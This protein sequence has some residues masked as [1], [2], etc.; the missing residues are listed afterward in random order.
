MTSIYY[1]WI[2]ACSWHISLLV[3]A[4]LFILFKRRTPKKK[5]PEFVPKPVYIWQE[6]NNKFPAE[7]S[8][9]VVKPPLTDIIDVSSSDVFGKRFLEGET[10]KVYEETIEKYGVGSCGPREFYGT[11]DIHKNF[12]SL[13]AETLGFEEGVLYSSWMAM[14]YSILKAIGDNEDTIIAYDV[15]VRMPYHEILGVCKTKHKYQF[16]LKTACQ[17]NPNVYEEIFEQVY[18]DWEKQFRDER[19][20]K[21]KWKKNEKKFI[22]IEGIFYNTGMVLRNVH[23]LIEAAQKWGFYVILDD[24]WALGIR[25]KNCLGSLDNNSVGRLSRSNIILLSALES[26]AFGSQGGICLCSHSIADFQ[27]LSASG[28]TFSASN[29]PY[30][31]AV[32]SETW[33][34][35]TQSYDYVNSDCP[36]KCASKRY[37]KLITDGFISCL[38]EKGLIYHL[39]FP[40]MPLKND[41][42]TSEHIFVL[43]CHNDRTKA[44]EVLKRWQNEC[45]FKATLTDDEKAVRIILY[46]YA[47]EKSKE[48]N[49]LLHKGLFLDI[50]TVYMEVVIPGFS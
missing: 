43:D 41:K 33:K 17:H 7:E 23:K 26:A 18:T 2:T 37:L 31:V 15:N 34:W 5:D 1:D 22:L 13:V 11:M 40:P 20:A 16:E 30:L 47:G 21:S 46:S 48:K 38:E 24:T 27:R 44:A 32:A 10:K 19:M 25:G 49:M 42:K 35:V 36:V 8:E 3:C 6:L 45:N 9:N 29:P 12:E 28:Y 39:K 14:A 50:L 4:L